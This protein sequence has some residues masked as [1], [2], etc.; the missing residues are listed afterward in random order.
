MDTFVLH[1]RRQSGLV[2]AVTP[3]KVIIDGERRQS[4]KVGQCHDPA[5]QEDTGDAAHPRIAG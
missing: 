3:T 4:I 1:L 5:S 2:A